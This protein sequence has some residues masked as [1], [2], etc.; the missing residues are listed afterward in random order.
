MLQLIGL[1]SSSSFSSMV[2]VSIDN[3]A[4]DAATIVVVLAPNR[5]RLLADMSGALSGLGL[6]VTEASIS[7]SGNLATNR[8]VLQEAALTAGDASKRCGRKVRGHRGP[9]PS[10]CTCGHIYQCACRCAC[11]HA[12]RHCDRNCGP[13]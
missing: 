8:F 10:S 11:G 1:S 12:W 13:S 9:S 3:D 7:T 2:K 6:Q 5:R 4:L